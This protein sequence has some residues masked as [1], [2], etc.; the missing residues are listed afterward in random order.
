M[1]VCDMPCDILQRTNDG[2]DLAP[3][4][5][6]LLELAVNG[7]LNDRGKALFEKLHQEVSEGRYR[8]SFPHFSL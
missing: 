4:H 2:D 7:E 8:T 6:K 3:E 5:L 1:T